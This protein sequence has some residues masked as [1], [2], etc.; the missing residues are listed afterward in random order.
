MKKR[1]NT[2]IYMKQETVE[3]SRKESQ[4][5]IRDLFHIGNAHS[6]IVRL[7]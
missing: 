5:G 6:L 3:I 2:K 4:S 7:I 1:I